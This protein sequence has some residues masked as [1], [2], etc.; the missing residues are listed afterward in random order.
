MHVSCSITQAP[1]YLSS[2]E[3]VGNYPTR[4]S[5]ATMISHIQAHC[6]DPRKV[7]SPSG[8]RSDPRPDRGRLLYMAVDPLSRSTIIKRGQVRAREPTF[9]VPTVPTQTLATKTDQESAEARGLTH[10]ATNRRPPTVDSR[11]QPSPTTYRPPRR[12]KV[13][14]HN[15]QALV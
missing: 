12:L 4:S 13:Y 9:V 3:S 11:R 14:Q 8:N 2:K 1:T 7:I 15:P 5:F 6:D 10:L